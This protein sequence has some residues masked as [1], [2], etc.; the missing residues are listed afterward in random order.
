MEPQL[1]TYSE[2]LNYFNDYFKNSGDLRK[3]AILLSFLGGEKYQPH[4][5]FLLTL[6]EPFKRFSEDKQIHSLWTI[7]SESLNFAKKIIDSAQKKLTEINQP[8][9]LNE[10]KLHADI[11]SPKLEAFLEISKII[12]KNDEGFYGLKDWPEINP[13]GVKNKAYVVFKKEQKPLHY[14]AVAKLIG[15]NA[16]PQTVHNELIKDPR[17][18]LVGRGMYAL[19]EWGYEA[20]QVKD[21]IAKVL[22]EA[23]R[24][25]S[26]EEVLERVFK[27]RLVKENTI[28]LNL[29]NR[30]Y[31]LKTPE[32]KYTIQK[33]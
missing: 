21:I 4:V 29:G 5:S 9:K 18:I 7:N 6:G 16:L 13:R 2:V 15:P 24:P 19:K 20:G 28:L 14:Q 3:E 30:K 23:E 22:R 32:G 26:K 8:I 11:P 27:Q 31:F 25:L 10:F 17:F 1:K 12:Q 33:F